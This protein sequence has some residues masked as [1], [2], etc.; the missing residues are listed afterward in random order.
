MVN[1]ANLEDKILYIGQPGAT[2]TDLYTVPTG[3]KARITQIHACNTNS[4][5]KYFSLHVVESGDSVADDVCFAK[6]Q[7]LEGTS[8][9]KG[10][11]AWDS[12]ITIPLVAGDKISGIQETATAITVMIFGILEEV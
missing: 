8:S 1:T 7:E 10:G 11:E 4:A 9:V 2:D 3:Y 12:D 6:N 5:T